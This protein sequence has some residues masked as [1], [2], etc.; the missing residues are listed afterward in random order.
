ME[1]IIEE[2]QLGNCDT[3]S[4]GQLAFSSWTPTLQPVRRN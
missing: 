3:D 2:F 1:Q 4:S